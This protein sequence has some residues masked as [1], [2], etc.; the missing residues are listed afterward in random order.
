MI[1]FIE[2]PFYEGCIVW[3][4]FFFLQMYCKTTIIGTSVQVG[5]LEQNRRRALGDLVNQGSVFRF[6]HLRVRFFGFGVLCGLR[7][8]YNSAFDFRFLSPM[9]AGFRIFLH[10]AF[11]GFATDI[12]PRSRAKTAIPRGLTVRGMHDKLSSPPPPL[13]SLAAVI[14]VVT[15]L[16]LKYHTAGIR[17]CGL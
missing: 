12:T 5:L 10:N 4:S 3:H 6:S 17:S 7:V 2:L 15:R 1:N 16:F 14:W 13:V 9:M 11:Y 8:F